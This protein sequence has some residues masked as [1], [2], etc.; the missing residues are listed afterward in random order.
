MCYIMKCEWLKNESNYFVTC[1]YFRLIRQPLQTE[2]CFHANVISFTLK[3]HFALLVP[4]MLGIKSRLNCCVCVYLLALQLIWK[5]NYPFERKTLLIPLN[6]FCCLVEKK[7]KFFQI[8]NR[9]K[10]MLMFLVLL[11]FLHTYL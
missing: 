4:T 9:R 5:G 10:T 6:K 1:K 11:Y 2:K 8:F 7:E 3:D